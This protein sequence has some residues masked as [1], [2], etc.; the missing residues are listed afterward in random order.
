MKGGM[1]V[2]VDVVRDKNGS[3]FHVKANKN[4]K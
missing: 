3:L 2:R 1:Y 4:I